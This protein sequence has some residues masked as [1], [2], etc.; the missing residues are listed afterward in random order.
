MQQPENLSILLVDDDPIVIRILNR[1]LSEFAPLRFAT[2]GR[3]ALKL[4]REQIPDLVLLDV[5][6][7]EM[8]GFETCMAFKADPA[9]AAVPIIFITGHDSPELL[10]KGFE[11][12]ATDFIIKPPHPPLVLARV[13]ACQRVKIL[14]DTLHNAVTID[15]L[16]GALTRNEFDVA[17]RN[18]WGRALRTSAPLSFMLVEIGAVTEPDTRLQALAAALRS[19]AH[20]PCDVLGRYADRQLALLLPETDRQGAHV[21]AQ[22]ALAV[23][24]ALR[25]SISVGVG[26][27]NDPRTAQ[28]V[29]AT[30]VS[31]EDL[32]AATDLA[33]G[34]AKAAGDGRA[35]CL[36][37]IEM[38]S[39]KNARASQ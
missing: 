17:A 32:I 3:A 6:M 29:P 13:R 11:L 34:Q 35:V 14:S 4:A 37:A 10:T 18:E 7:P 1:I 39:L 22:R 12:G 5:D 15:F 8:S 20:R 9:L 30:D 19:V 2:S 27:R 24:E 21:V 25:L 16:T 33:L 26:T 31:L 28:A 38:C 23:I 36:E